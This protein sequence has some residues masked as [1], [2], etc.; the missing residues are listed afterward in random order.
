M[1]IKKALLTRD[2]ACAPDGHTV[3]KFQTGESVEGNVAQMALA[4][5][6]AIEVQSFIAND[7]EKKDNAAQEFEVVK[8]ASRKKSK[9]RSK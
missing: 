8:N 3:L 5:G 1:S 9:E 6:A 2:Y 7:L 4:D